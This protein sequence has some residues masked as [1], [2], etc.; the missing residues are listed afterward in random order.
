MDI[1]NSDMMET[2]ETLIDGSRDEKYQNLY[3]KG[4]TY[5][6]YSTLI[7]IVTRGRKTTSCTCECGK[8]VSI[9]YQPGFHPWVVES[10]KRLIKPMNV[11]VMEMVVSGEEVG[12]AYE[13]AI[14]QMLT[15]PV[16]KAFKFIL[17]LEDDVIIPF[18]PGSFGPLIEMYKHLET[19]D[20]ASALYWTKSD[21]PVPLLYGDGKMEAPIFGVNNMWRPGDIVE[22]NGTGMGFTLMKR[23]IFED[24]RI[25][26]PFFKSVNFVMD[27]GPVS[28]TQDLYFYEKI[29]KLG[30]KICVDTRIRA[31]HLDIATERVY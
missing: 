10:W 5:K 9:E 14:E 8:Q 20:V 2:L 27:S 6:D 22:V 11:P 23:S 4:Q 1:I 12:E 19:Y 17:F 31:G 30:Y 26:R 18:I 15:D 29:K 13:R 28:Y 16:L 25:E 3:L 24:K 7:I 21:P